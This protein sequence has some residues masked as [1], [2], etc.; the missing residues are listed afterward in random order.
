[1]TK[2]ARRTCAWLLAGACLAAA[3]CGD[4]D[5]AADDGGTGDDVADTADDTGGEATDDGASEVP[6]DGTTE[7]P[8]DASTDDGGEPL[9]PTD[10][11]LPWAGGSAYYASWSNGPPADPSY[12]PIAV[13][14]QAPR[15]AAAYAA[16][17]VNLFVGLWEGP[18][19]AQLTELAGASM[20]V[21]CDQNEVGLAHLADPTIL[22]WM[23]QDEPDNAQSDGSGG[24]GPCVPPETIRDLGAAMRAA[25]PSRPV[26]LNL[27]Q[28]VAWDD[29]VGRGV[30]SDH[31][32]HYPIYSEGADIVSFDIY[33]ATSDREAVAGNLWYVAQGVERLRGWVADAKPVWTW[34]ET[35]HISNPD[36]RVTPHQLRAEVWM[37]LI[38]GA[39]GL[40]YFCHEFEPSFLEAGL[41]HYDDVREEAAALNA[42]IRE[43]APVLN[44]QSVGNAVTVTSSDAAV[45]V[46]TMVKRTP[47]AT[48][49]FAVAMRDAPTRA[50]FTLTCVAPEATAEVL[51]EDRTVALS[52][53]VLTD[54]FAGYDVHLYRVVD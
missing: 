23:H 46:A 28:G 5:A 25:D 31:N 16:I 33:P 12:F 10:E 47:E 4:D 27:G 52:G 48:W 32:E 36:V 9:C 24:W 42:R 1:M 19:D 18:T 11:L 3:G 41:L 17:G 21:V 43:L 6:D 30:C 26:Y 7:T 39:M 50:T 34:I 51:G 15:N 44:T 2:L 14:L 8:D 29:W 54:D 53:A 37:A 20:P 38:H 49:L 35:T 45:P 40:G 22:S 13:W